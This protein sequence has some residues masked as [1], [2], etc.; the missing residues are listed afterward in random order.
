MNKIIYF[1]L[2]TVVTVSSIYSKEPTIATLKAVYSNAHL[3]FGIS[4]REFL[5][6]PY[7]LIT[8]D[9]LYL[10]AKAGSTCKKS[11]DK[12]YMQNPRDKYY[13]SSLLKTRQN[14]HV[15]FKNNRCILYARG[16]VTLSELL[17]KKGLAIKASTFKD[18]EFDYYF[19][20]AQIEAK[21][22]NIGIYKNKIETK[23]ISEV[24]ELEKRDL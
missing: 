14:Y 24:S 5:C 2:I 19:S 1:L 7:G 20:E 10:Q 13:S 22:K 17:L 4:K 23:C 11:I 3:K 18:V 16:L 21:E 6:K 9:E 8:I 15:E 12:Y